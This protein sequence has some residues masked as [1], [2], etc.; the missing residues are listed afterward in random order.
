MIGLCL[1]YEQT[2]YGSKLQALAT[3]NVV[4]QLGYNFQII[5]YAKGGFW[6]KIKSL[7]RVLNSTFRQDKIEDFSRRR[8]IKRHP[9][10]AQSI[11]ERKRMFKE[12][13]AIFF[14]KYEIRGKYYKDIKR[15]ATTYD[16]V[17][18][19]SDQLWSPAGL[20][21]NF[22]NL[23]FVPDHINKVSFA[24]SF[25]VSQILLLSIYAFCRRQSHYRLSEPCHNLSLL[26][27]PSHYPNFWEHYARFSQHAVYSTGTATPPP[28][29]A[30][31]MKPR[32]NSRLFP[33]G[34][35][36]STCITTG[37]V[38]PS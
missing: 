4:E 28:G 34:A 12:F 13:D 27:M 5:H 1:K 21:T 35:A 18:S 9:V 32:T 3:I 25:G 23:M 11:Q 38:R 10:V 26:W 31:S 29:C 7:S 37:R 2:N 6:F 22:Y 17:V 8:A 14:D 19:C 33:A 36:S 30:T 16:S 24:S 15:I 20:G